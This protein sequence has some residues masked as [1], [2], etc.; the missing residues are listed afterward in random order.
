MCTS[1]EDKEN[2]KVSSAVRLPK[3]GIN[4][5]ARDISLFR[6]TNPRLTKQDLTSFPYS[7]AMFCLE[8]VFNRIWANNMLNM[9]GDDPLNALTI[10]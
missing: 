4:I 2:C 6:E 1:F 10:L 9:N 3:G 7:Y 8:F 5:I